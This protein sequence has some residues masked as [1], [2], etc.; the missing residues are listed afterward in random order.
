MVAYKT[1]GE[2]YGRYTAGKSTHIYSILM[3]ILLT[4]FTR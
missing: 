4:S 2:A 3:E 1:S